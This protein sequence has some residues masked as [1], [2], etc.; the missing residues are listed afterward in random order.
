VGQF[1]QGEAQEL[2]DEIIYLQARIGEH[3]TM[4]QFKGQ[5][6]NL[7]IGRS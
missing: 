4:Q 6:S 2:R 3:V 7:L 1:G 5:F